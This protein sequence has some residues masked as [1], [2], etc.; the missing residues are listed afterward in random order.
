MSTKPVVAKEATAWFLAVEPL[1]MPVAETESD[2]NS[3]NLAQRKP[4][5]SPIVGVESVIPFSTPQRPSETLARARGT[6]PLSK[7]LVTK[8]D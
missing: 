3:P 4:S 7:E 2:N 5:S 1:L 8:S 6:S